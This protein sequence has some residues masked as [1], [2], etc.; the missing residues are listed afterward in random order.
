MG[1]IIASHNIKMLAPATA[2]NAPVNTCNCKVK[3]SCPLDGQCQ[4][5]SIVYK[6]SVF[7]PPNLLRY[8]TE[9]LKGL[10]RRG[11]ITIPNPSDI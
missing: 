1:A 5:A 11:T 7:A 6:A 3:A 8:T 2:G 9:P 4:T 10:S